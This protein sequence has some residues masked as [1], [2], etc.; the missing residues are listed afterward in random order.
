MLSLNFT[1]SYSILVQVHLRLIIIVLVI[2][3][4]E[5]ILILIFHAQVHL[6]RVLSLLHVQGVLIGYAAGVGADGSSLGA[7]EAARWET[8]STVDI[9][10]GGLDG[11]LEAFAL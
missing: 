11:C 7:V 5:A 1:S 2:I 8:L 9:G 4:G 10:T 6:G 3:A